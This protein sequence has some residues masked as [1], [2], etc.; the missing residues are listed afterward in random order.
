[1]EAPV[2]RLCSHH[3]SGL[4]AAFCGGCLE[5]SVLPLALSAGCSLLKFLQCALDMRLT[6]VPGKLRRC[7]RSGQD[8][9]RRNKRM[10]ASF[11]SKI[12]SEKP[13]FFSPIG[14]SAKGSALRVRL[15]RPDLLRCACPHLCAPKGHWL[16]ISCHFPSLQRGV[17]LLA[18]REAMRASLT[19]SPMIRPSCQD[20]ISPLFLPP[21]LQ[22]VSVACHSFLPSAVGSV[23]TEICH[24]SH[25]GRVGCHY[26]S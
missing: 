5:L 17:Y 8:R 22:D 12:T 2:K 21:V 20:L 26:Y 25:G 23:D 9:V 6:C 18:L 16:T 7:H 1:M 24:S 10:P 19:N 11:I 3:V 15:L 14:S 4:R 13:V